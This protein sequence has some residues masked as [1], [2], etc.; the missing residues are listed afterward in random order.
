VLVGDLIEK[1]RKPCETALEDA[2]LEPNQ[3]DEVI[4]VGGQTRTPRVKAVVQEIF[5]RTPNDQANPE[6]VV[7]LGAALQAG[8]L[9][10][11][12]K[13][14]VL[15][16]VTPLS[17]GIETRGGVFTR[18]IERNSNIPTKKS[19]VFTTVS[20]NQSKV[21][22]HVLQGERAVAGENKSLGRFDLVGIPPA[23]K[24]VPQIEVTFD[25]DSNGIVDVSARDK[26]TGKEQAIRVTP[27]GG[28]S[29]EEIRSIIEDAK[30]HSEEDKQRLEVQRLRTRLEAMLESTE[31]SLRTFGT[32]LTPGNRE[33][34]EEAIQ[35]AK[36]SLESES[37]SRVNQ[38]L[39]GLQDVGRVLTEVMLYDPE[40]IS[41]DSG[42]EIES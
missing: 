25:I 33:T 1:T 9:E 30:A 8:I 22:V 3:V 28:L 41:P 36:R 27:S 40:Q 5:D 4:L 7:G 13:D 23:P 11:E 17:L 39:A 42:G 24:G 16:D 15:L 37:V 2:D 31:R 26:V 18:I 21:E 38:S 12:V 29:E 20:D 6:E 34:V 14:L 19:M 32:M 35:N 10:G